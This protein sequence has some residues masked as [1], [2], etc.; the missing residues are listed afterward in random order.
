M[1]R[2]GNAPPQVV[3]AYAERI[4]K[5]NHFLTLR[6]TNE[7][8]HYKNGIYEPHGEAVIESNAQRLVPGL[9][10]RERR[11][12][13]ERVRSMT[14]CDRG[15]FDDHPLMLNVQNGIFDLR[16]M[17]LYVHT[18]KIPFL[19]QMNVT[20]D[21]EAKAPRYNEFVADMVRDGRYRT[22]LHEIL[23]SALL[24]GRINLERA[25]VLVSKD[26]GG[27]SVLSRAVGSI[28][29]DGLLNTSIRELTQ[30][31]FLRPSLRGRM[32]NVLYDDGLPKMKNP[33]LL[34]AMISGGPMTVREKYQ[35]PFTFSPHAVLM[36][37]AFRLPAPEKCP[38]SIRR[39]LAVIPAS[40]MS[41]YIHIPQVVRWLSTAKERSGILN[42][43]LQHA[44]NLL[45][46]GRL[47][48]EPAPHEARQTWFEWSS[49]KIAA[50]MK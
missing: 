10:I 15:V 13:V 43:L 27:T 17:D 7:I 3:A 44:G 2:I 50:R 11:D 24:R 42:V 5:R 9:N 38:D 21:G 31:P 33:W 4:M 19:T 47:T 40:P 34:D 23:A 36:F 30:E 18:P 45:K 29:G 12:I 26:D 46:N 25:V 1:V 22:L 8:F 14:Y 39:R 41:Q 28:F 37:S 20:F 32:L 35:K 6:D 16:T 48:W 49:P